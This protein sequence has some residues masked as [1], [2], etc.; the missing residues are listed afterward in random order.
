M[1]TRLNHDIHRFSGCPDMSDENFAGN[2]SGVALR[3]KLLQFE[4]IAGIKEREFKR[5][6][7]RRIELLC[8][9]LSVL[10]RP[11]YDWRSVRVTFKRAL[12]QNLLELSQTLSNLGTLLSDE[13]KRA[14][15]P[16]EID[17]AAEAE[18]IAGQR[19]SNMS[20]FNFSHEDEEDGGVDV[21]GA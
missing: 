6:L 19:E 16:L 17:E 11:A 13:T 18:R 15:L 20:L 1:K 5:G 3:Y 9:I 21:D 7:Q 14:L 12:P 2:A 8:N 10:G 4:N